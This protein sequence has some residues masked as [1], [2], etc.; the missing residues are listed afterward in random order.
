MASAEYREHLFKLIAGFTVLTGLIGF[1]AETIYREFFES[2]VKLALSED[3]SYI[4]V[5]FFTVLTVLYLAARYTGFSYGVRLSKL[6]FSDTSSHLI[7]YL[8]SGSR[9]FRA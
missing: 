3:Y 8:Y 9:R 7:I 4:I 2:I 6:F 5:S 1:L